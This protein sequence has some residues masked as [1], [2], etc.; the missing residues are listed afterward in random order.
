MESFPL[1]PS[2]DRLSTA[3]R[4]AQLTQS[5]SV[6]ARQLRRALATHTSACGVSDTEF[7]LLWSCAQHVE[8]ISQSELAA[9]IGV[10]PAQLSGLVERLRQRGWLDAQRSREDRRRQCWR[11]TDEGRTLLDRG[12]EALTPLASHLEQSTSAEELKAA[13]QLLRDIAKGSGVF[14]SFGEIGDETDQR[15]LPKLKKTPDPVRAGR[16]SGGTEAA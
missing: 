6:C 5:V 3:E 16:L 2:A 12:L 9:A 8:G 7:L 15:P 13:E 11:L 4:C 10:S 1:E 14:F